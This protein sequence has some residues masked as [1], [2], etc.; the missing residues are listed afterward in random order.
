V[1]I[2]FLVQ[3]RIDQ[4]V[5][6]AIGGGE[7]L[8][9]IDNATVARAQ[10]DLI[11]TQ[12]LCNVCAPS[13]AHVASAAA[14]V[15]GARHYCSSLTFASL[16]SSQRSFFTAKYSSWYVSLIIWQNFKNYGDGASRRKMRSESCY[17]IPETRGDENAEWTITVA[18]P[19][20]RQ[21]R[22]AGKA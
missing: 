22:F 2:R 16:F 13:S 8:Y 14:A 5:N 11:I 9:G 21:M 3:A 12:T 10:P 15:R 20:K 19:K 18:F 6:E 7:G 1:S 17:F 4:L